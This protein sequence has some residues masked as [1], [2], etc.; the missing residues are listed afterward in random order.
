MAT[1]IVMM[2]VVMT[3]GW[4]TTSALHCSGHADLNQTKDVL[5]DDVLDDGVVDDVL[6]DD[7]FHVDNVLA[8]DVPFDDVI[9]DDILDEQHEYAGKG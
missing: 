8:D 2:T 7:D 1:I 9:H 4:L 5:G 3:E 6:L